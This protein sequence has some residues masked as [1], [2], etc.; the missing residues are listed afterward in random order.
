MVRYAERNN[1]KNSWEYNLVL[2]RFKKTMEQALPSKQVE[3]K[4]NKQEN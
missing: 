4:L 2:K 1:S 3:E